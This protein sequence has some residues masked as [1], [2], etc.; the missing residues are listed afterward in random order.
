MIEIDRDDDTNL[1]VMKDGPGR[2]MTQVNMITGVSGSTVAV[3]NPFFYDFS[4]GNP[5]VKFTFPTVTHNSGVENMKFDHDGFTGCYFFMTQYC[6]SCWVKGV[7]SARAQ[8]YHFITM[9]TLNAEFR[10]SYIHDGSSG[11]NNSGINFYGNYQ[12]GANSSGKIENNIFNKNFPAIEINNSSSGLYIGYNYAHGSVDQ[13]GSQMVTWTFDD[14]HAPFNVANLY[15]GNTGEMWGMDG[16]FGGS[17][18]G[19]VLRNYITGFNANY[20]V[21]GDAIQIKRLGYYYNIVGNVLGSANQKPT[22]YDTGCG[23]TNIFQLGYPNIGNCGTT[24]YDGFSPAGGYPDPKVKSSLVRWGNY[25]YF[26]KAVRWESS[27]VSSDVQLPSN[28]T[29]PASLYYSARPTWF[30]A[31]VPWPLVGPDVTGGDGDSAGHVYKSPAQR[32]W[33]S[34]NLNG[35]GSFNAAACYP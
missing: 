28:Y 24:P 6:D 16:Y 29:I 35:S 12:Y 18:M 21:S 22:A 10:D 11:P 3:R 34:R 27:E 14:G 20:S 17:G 26:N 33:E 30:P 19:T 31:A 15:E 7:E 1:I 32:C 8:G 9:G 23:V 4:K 13:Y 5:K 25:D 2:N